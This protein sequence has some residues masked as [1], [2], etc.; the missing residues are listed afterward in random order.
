MSPSVPMFQFLAA[1]AQ[2]LDTNS[3]E[4]AEAARL[5]ALEMR[6]RLVGGAR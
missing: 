5:A 1:Q 4:V 2:N 3:K 6:E